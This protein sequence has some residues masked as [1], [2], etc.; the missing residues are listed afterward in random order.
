[1]A[2]VAF[3]KL[4]L[5][6]DTSIVSFP[7]EGNTIEVKRYL[8]VEE[9]LKIIGNIV[10][11]SLDANNF[12]NPCRL[13]VFY[14][15]ETILAYTNITITDKQKEDNG[16]L[17]DLFVSSGFKSEVFNRISDEEKSYIWEGCQSILRSI[18]DY[19][20]SAMGIMN[21]ITTDYKDLDLNAEEIQ[22]KL[23]DPEN[24]QLLKGVLTKLG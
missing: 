22:G 3:G 18:Y 7:W 20:N 10:G 17:Y 11:E 16:K 24:L 1:M 19:K 15:I 5:N 23:A 4:K 14:I 8:P 6:K 2:N 21:A 9:K 12:C 13:E